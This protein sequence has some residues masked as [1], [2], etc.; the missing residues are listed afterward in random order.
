MAKDPPEGEALVNIFLREYQ[1]DFRVG[2]AARALQG[3]YELQDLDYTCA[4][5]GD[6]LHVYAQGNDLLPCQKTWVERLR[7]KL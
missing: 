2:S 7:L 5:V 4:L 3:Q 6:A 1:R